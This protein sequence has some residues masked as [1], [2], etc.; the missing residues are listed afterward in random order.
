MLFNTKDKLT[1]PII[2][3]KTNS[4][5]I[6]EYLAHY[7]PKIYQRFSATPFFAWNS[8][9]TEMENKYQSVKAASKGINNLWETSS[10]DILFGTNFGSVGFWAPGKPIQT[11]ETGTQGA[12]ES[13]IEID[14]DFWLAANEFGEILS[15]H[16]S[17]ISWKMHDR[18]FIH[19]RILNLN[20]YKKTIF[21]SVHNGDS[22][23]I[24]YKN[25]KDKEWQKIFTY[26]LKINLWSGVGA[27][28]ISISYNEKLVT[29][30]PSNNLLITDMNT[31]ISQEKV[32]PGSIVYFNI[33][34]DGTIG[35]RV[36]GGFS[37]KTYKSED[38]GDT[39]VESNSKSYMPDYFT[40][41]NTG[42]NI[43][44]K[45]GFA[46]SKYTIIQTINGGKSWN[47]SFTLPGKIDLFSHL[48]K[49]GYVFLHDQD[50][51]IFM[52]KDKG[53]T[54]EQ[55]YNYRK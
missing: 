24:F 9:T 52:S 54:W 38:W 30:L 2:I 4:P 55:Q 16:N 23:S 40:D 17:G 34:Y 44:V 6:K 53:K 21:A 20:I 43:S 33:S 47:K 26:P 5:W 48:K 37:H 28:P 22:L 10:G 39:W 32:F 25:R 14:T 42:Y 50:S 11:Y 41:A 8:L 31:L 12:I 7:H 15:S 29:S 45:A 49:S 1:D 18:T 35:A 3:G 19:H 13:V 46:N 27:S 36:S 51:T